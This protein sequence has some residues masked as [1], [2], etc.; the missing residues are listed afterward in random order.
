MLS[1]TNLTRDDLTPFSSS[2]NLSVTV[3]AAAVNQNAFGAVLSVGVLSWAIITSW[4]VT[5]DRWDV[6]CARQHHARMFLTLQNPTSI[7]V[8]GRTLSART[9]GVPSTTNPQYAINL[10]S[11]IKLFPAIL[12]HDDVLQA[13]WYN[14]I[15]AEPS[16]LGTCVATIRVSGFY[17]RSNLSALGMKP[18]AEGTGLTLP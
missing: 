5:L 4:D 8:Q 1:N 10:N 18:A 13:E 2:V 15:Y 3:V 12:V 9:T 6:W 17:S 11:N 16:N 14:T 7:T